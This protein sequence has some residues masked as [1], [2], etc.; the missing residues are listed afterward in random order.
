MRFDI[1]NYLEK[2][3]IQLDEPNRYN[4]EIELIWTGKTPKGK[5]FYIHQSGD[6]FRPHFEL[7][8]EGER[9]KPNCLPETIVNKIKNN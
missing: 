3:N 9:C 4:K 7:I 2:N 1:R 8:I 5:G 6:G